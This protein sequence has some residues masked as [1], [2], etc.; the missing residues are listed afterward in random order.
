[1]QTIKLTKP[2][3]ITALS[4]SLLFL[5]GCGGGSD[6]ESSSAGGGGN[7]DITAPIISNTSPVDNANDAALNSIVTATFNEDILSTSVN[8]TSFTLAKTSGGITIGSISF[9]GSSNIASFTPTDALSKSTTYTATLNI[10][11]TDLSGNALASNYNWSFTTVGGGWRNA[12]PIETDFPSATKPQI[13]IN[14]NGKA[15]AVWEQDDNIMANRFDG[16]SWGTAEPIEASAGP[17][18]FPQ[19]IIDSNGKALAVWQQDNKIMAN[20][21]DGTIWGTAE[22]IDENME[23]PN[24]P[25]IAIDDNGNALAVWQAIDLTGYKIMANHF[26]GSSWGTAEQIV[27]N[28]A[29]KSMPQVAIN[30][31]GKALAVWRQRNLTGNGFKIWANHFNGSSWGT[32]EPIETSS[33]TSVT[34]PQIA[35]DNNGNALTVWEQGNDIMANRFDGTSSS[36]GTDE[37]IEA[38]AGRA[39]TPQIT[40]DNNGNALAVWSQL[41][42][43]YFNIMSNRFDGTSSSWGTSEQIETG[44]DHST[45]PQI[46]IDNNGNAIAVWMQSTLI[47]TNHFNG[48]IWGVFEQIGAGGRFTSSPQIAIDNNGN[49]L[50]VWQQADFSTI[51]IMASR[52][53]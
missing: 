18:T 23:N 42:D 50:A 6:N 27:A 31:N 47:M 45:T 44:A 49:A 41:G 1:M 21:F 35:I 33:S 5:S 15:L 32:S 16:T 48:T 17:A 11:I 34:P 36:W 38:D 22:S 12:E 3:L 28:S 43:T 37:P 25:Q 9:D 51:N 39:V 53:E 46:A 19:I 40:F 24:S 20:R 7:E 26:D 13:A 2:F 8:A 10:N 14:N 52:F 29:S 4:V 30:N